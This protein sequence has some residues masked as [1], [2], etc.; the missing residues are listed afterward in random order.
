MIGHPINFKAD[1]VEAFHDS[2][3][4]RVEVVLDLGRDVWNSILRAEG[5]VIDLEAL[6]KANL[7]TASITRAKI[8]LSGEVNRPLTIKAV[9]VTKGARAAIEA[10]GGTSMFDGIIRGTELFADADDD[11]IRKNMIVLTDGADENSVSDLAAASAAVSSAGIRTFGVA[12]ESDAFNPADLQQIVG[13]A[14]G[15]FLSTSDPEEL[16]SDRPPRQW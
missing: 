6:R 15:L 8:M 14:N 7:I 1:A 10:A 3:H 2:C 4:V 13:A 12:L 5:D 9:G 16:D 11:Q